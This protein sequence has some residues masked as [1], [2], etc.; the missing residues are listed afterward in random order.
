M[1]LRITTPLARLR[2]ALMRIVLI[3]LAIPQSAS[4][5]TI[6]SITIASATT[7][8][9]AFS[10]ASP[11]V[12]GT[13]SEAD[14]TIALTVPYGTD[15]TALVPTIAI[16][17]SSVSPASG[18]ATNFTNPVTYTVSAADGRTTK[19]YRATVAIASDTSAPKVASIAITGADHGSNVSTYWTNIYTTGDKVTATVTFSKAVT[20]T[21][22]PTLAFNIGGTS[23]SADYESGSGTATLTFTYILENKLVTTDGISVS[24]NSLAL[25][26]GAIKD[27]ASNEATIT[28]AVMAANAHYQVLTIGGWYGGGTIGCFIDEGE[29]LGRLLNGCD[30]PNAINGTKETPHGLILKAVDGSVQLPELPP[31]VTSA[32][33]DV[34]Y[35]D[36]LTPLDFPH[37]NKPSTGLG[38]GPSNTM[39]IFKAFNKTGNDYAAGY[40]MQCNQQQGTDWYLP[41]IGELIKVYNAGGIPQENISKCFLSSSPNT[42][43]YSNIWNEDDL[44]YSMGTCYY[45]YWIVQQKPLFPEYS[46]VSISKD[47][48]VGD[49]NILL[50]RS[51]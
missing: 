39:A 13:V 46:M 20:V 15:V 36:G 26:G 44:R 38:F 2:G 10:F 17:G 28:H 27:T 23:K 7:A 34:Q 6:R 25:N 22:T 21:G 50:L 48:D 42:Y 35:P 47:S 29:S 18:T 37:T 11:A 30:I 41:S 40:I 3:A 43:T 8:I 51:F 19:D 1:N 9:N 14:K 33:T 12:T 16:T 49:L 24:E 5:V 31:A 4:A 32:N 45:T